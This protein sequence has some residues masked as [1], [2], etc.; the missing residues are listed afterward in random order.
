VIPFGILESSFRAA[1][2]ERWGLVGET[3]L[4]EACAS[5][6]PALRSRLA[7]DLAA[8]AAVVALPYG[9]GR[10]APVPALPAD[11]PLARI[12]R[13]AR[14]DWYAE[15]SARLKTVSALARASL[16]GALGEQ[17]GASAALRSLEAPG[18][19]ARDWRYF[20]NSRLPEK[21][22]ALE[23]GLG[24]L[25]RNSLVLAK[26]AGSALVIGVLLL[27]IPV[28]APSAEPALGPRPGQRPEGPGILRNATHSARQPTL[29]ESC[30][31]CRACVEACPTGALRGEGGLDR[32]LCLQHWSSISGALP[33]AVEA[34]WGNRLYGCDVCQE[35]CPLY[36]PAKDAVTSR[37]RLGEGLSAAWIL[38]SSEAELRSALRG[39][40]LGMS[41]ISVEALKRNAELVLRWARR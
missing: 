15:L 36:A 14:A 19:A 13:F 29:A 4:R 39:S 24:A 25:G 33:P 5:L 2:L 26:G 17:L 34:A 40:A 9:E 38:R 31:D 23:A 21:R 3:A 6:S 11:E 1:G 10:E 27:P 18:L 8:G 30:V 32:E 28:S 7:L 37:G 35:A 16:R 20:V 22:L 41:W 12:A